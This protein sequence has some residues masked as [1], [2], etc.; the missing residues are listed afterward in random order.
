MLTIDHSGNSMKVSIITENHAAKEML[1]SN[2]SELRTTLSSAGISLDSFEVD[3]SSDF[4]QS[5][6]DTG[7]SAGNFNRKNGSNTNSDGTDL[8]MEDDL[9]GIPEGVDVDGAYH[10]V[11]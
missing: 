3:M 7:N 8:D 4:K 2:V 9:A 6:A 5:M 11:A 10:F 1:A